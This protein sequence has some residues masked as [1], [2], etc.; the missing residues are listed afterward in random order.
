MRGLGIGNQI[1]D[2]FGAAPK[3]KHREAKITLIT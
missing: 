3:G 2:Q 1:H